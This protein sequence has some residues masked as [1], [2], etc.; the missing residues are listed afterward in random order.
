M[1]ELLIGPYLLG[2]L[3]VCAEQLNWLFEL[4]SYQYLKEFQQQ[5]ENIGGVRPYLLIRCEIML[6]SIKFYFATMPASGH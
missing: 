2:L 3:D 1:S 6:C 5:K 4:I